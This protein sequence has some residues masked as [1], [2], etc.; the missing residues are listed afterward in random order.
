M[1]VHLQEWSISVILSFGLKILLRRDLVLFD[2]EGQTLRNDP[3]KPLPLFPGQ[4]VG[5]TGGI[6]LCPK[7]DLVRIDISDA[8]DDTLIQQALLDRFLSP[9]QTSAQILR[10]KCVIKRLFTQ[11]SDAAVCILFVFLH[12]PEPSEPAG[13]GKTQFT[14]VFHLKDQ[15]CMLLF[16]MTRRCK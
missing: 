13:I 8:G 6:D 11:L 16:R 9:L 4:T 7:Q 5:R 14:A 3:C 12:E 1:S 15:M 10:G 2:K